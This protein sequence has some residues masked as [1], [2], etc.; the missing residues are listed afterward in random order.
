MP[1]ESADFIFFI[2]LTCSTLSS[3]VYNLLSNAVV[4]KMQ[5]PTAVHIAA[6]TRADERDGA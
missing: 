6:E 1:Q 3:L 5:A 2:D 4:S